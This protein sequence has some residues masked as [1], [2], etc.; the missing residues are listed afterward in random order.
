MLFLHC[1]QELAFPS[2]LSLRSSDKIYSSTVVKKVIETTPIWA[3]KLKKA[4]N[5]SMH[6]SNM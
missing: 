2:R 1:S 3:Y 4:Y 5:N 6:K